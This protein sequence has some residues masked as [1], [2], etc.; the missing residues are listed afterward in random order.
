MHD[1]SRV[2][3]SQTFRDMLEI[4]QDP[5]QVRGQLEH[6]FA[7]PVS[8]DELHGDEMHAFGFADFI[9]VGNVR[10]VQGGCGFCF[11]HEAAHAIGI[12]GE[13]GG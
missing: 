6:A 4:A 10:M 8:V 2:C 13:L 3:F 1:P 5:S 12:S 7:Q 9:N 11:L